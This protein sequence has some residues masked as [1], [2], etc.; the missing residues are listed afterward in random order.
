MIPGTSK[1]LSKS[2]L[3]HLLIITKMLQKIQEKIWNHLGKILSSGLRPTPPPCFSDLVYRIILL[4][5]SSSGLKVFFHRSDHSHPRVAWTIL[6]H[7]GAILG[8]IGPSWVIL[9]YPEGPRSWLTLGGC[10]LVQF[11][12]FFVFF[13]VVLGGGIFTELSSHA[14]KTAIFE[15]SPKNT[16]KQL[17]ITTR[18]N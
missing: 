8:H 2:G 18:E 12:C 1:I 7:L 11:W 4:M 10:F 9:G 17:K 5:L 3:Q 14:G 6:G 13:F 15:G 16:K